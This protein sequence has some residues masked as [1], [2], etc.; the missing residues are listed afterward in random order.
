MCCKSI[1]L[2]LTITIH[3]RTKKASLLT[4]VYLKHNGAEQRKQ[5]I[6]RCIAPLNVVQLINQ[7]FTVRSPQLKPNWHI[8]WSQ[9]CGAEWKNCHKM[10]CTY[11]SCKMINYIITVRISQLKTLLLT[12]IYLD[13][14][15]VEQKINLVTRCIVPTRS[16]IAVLWR[17]GHLL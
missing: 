9:E 8:L 16:L 3:Q 13:Q 6:I 12:D 4:G 11:F 2:S 14:D 17:K 1:N 15:S 10:Q 5:I 7:C